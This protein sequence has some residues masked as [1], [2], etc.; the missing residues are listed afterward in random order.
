MYKWIYYTL[1]QSASFR[2]ERRGSG[3]SKVDSA[4]DYYVSVYGNQATS[5]YDAHKKSDLRKVYNSIVK[6]NKES[7]LYKITNAD[8]AKK[9]AIDIK[10]HAKA[11]QNVVASLSDNYGEFSD[12]FQK[13]VAISSDEDTVEVT[14]VGDGKEKNLADQFEIQ[15][16]KLATPQI[17]TGNYLKGN[18]LSFVP[19]SYSF[20]LTTNASAYEFQFN[21][22]EGD[23]NST[24]QTKLANLINGSKLGIEASVVEKEDGTSALSLVS[25]QTGLSPEESYLFSIEPGADSASISAMNLL[26]IHAV[27]EPATNSDFLLNGT[28]QSSLS[29]TF[30]INNAFELSLKKPSEEGNPVTICFKANADAIADNIQTLLDT[31]NGAIKTAAQY[32][33]ESSGHGNRLFAELSSAVKDQYDSLT[34]IGIDIESDGTLSINRDTLA[35]ALAPER[36]PATFQ[37]LT[38][39]KD[40]I[41]SKANSAAIDPMKY[42]D[43]VVVEYKNPGRN[44]AAPYISSI[45]SGMMLDNYI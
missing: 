4:Y 43:K 2:E 44:F 18:A 22:N 17:N 38:D 23:T 29:N 1:M 20:D 14:Y 6:S 3:M 42:V 41:G 40:S 5:R 28:P 16:H 10:E 33:E 25:K 15:I 35:D 12:S 7:P 30:T 39:F 19:G 11:I 27:T 31:Y 24:V 45:Y 21:V 32:S 37:T 9:Y 8:N 34:A 36:A 26:G 13:K